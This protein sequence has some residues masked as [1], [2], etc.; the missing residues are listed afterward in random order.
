MRKAARSRPKQAFWVVVVN[1]GFLRTRKI[2][3]ALKKK[4]LQ[5]GNAK[6]LK[7]R[8]GGIKVKKIDLYAYISLHGA[9]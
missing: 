3:R 6:T 7:E 1:Y 4:L 5:R 2:F 9:L 8:E